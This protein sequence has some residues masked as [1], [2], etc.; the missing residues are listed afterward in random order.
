MMSM[1]LVHA[2]F[3]QIMT[4]RERTVTVTEVV[5]QT[6]SDTARSSSILSHVI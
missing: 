6:V 2:I 1:Q 4:T 5:S 3:F